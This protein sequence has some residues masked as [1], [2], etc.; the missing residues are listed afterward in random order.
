MD[1]YA[2]T[3]ACVSV[4]KKIGSVYNVSHTIHTRTQFDNAMVCAWECVRVWN[5]S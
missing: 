1:E 2:G 3:R 4:Q 5:S